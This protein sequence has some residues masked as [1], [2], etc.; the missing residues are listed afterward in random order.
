MTDPYIDNV[1]LALPF[2]Q[3]A[4]GLRGS[5][6]YSNYKQGLTWDGSS[7]LSDVQSKFGGTGCYFDGLN[8]TITVK[9]SSCF[10]FGSSD[11]TLELWFNPSGVTGNQAL[12]TKVNNIAFSPF[13][14]R[15]ESAF[16]KFYSS[17]D[18]ATTWDI[19]NALVIGT[20]ATS[21]WY[22]VAVTREGSSFKTFLNGVA[23]AGTSSAASLKDTVGYS[24]SVGGD[25]Y[26]ST[27][28]FKGYIDDFR[29]TKGI[30]RYT[31]D[32]TPPTAF[33]GDYPAPPVFS[34]HN[35]PSIY[36]KSAFQW[37]LLDKKG[38]LLSQIASHRM[39]NIGWWSGTGTLT[40]LIEIG[41]TP[42]KRKVRLYESSSG[43]LLWEKWANEDGTYTFDTVS[44][45][46]EFTITSPDCVG[47][48]NDV[49]AARVRAV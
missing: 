21:N 22:H 7:R 37:C 42:V 46:I 32:F 8:S 38:V 49:I 24:L 16:L 9:H 39:P 48:Y 34:A 30:A 28:W 44:K 45:A 36:G 12:I 4:P 3:D 23:G 11:F 35:L 19:A 40:G 27:H 5:L 1:V 47:T 14:I 25:K 43:V 18:L 10:T 17:S 33:K 13:L 6:D 41:T 15:L 20:V 26:A 2:D 31:E 29:I